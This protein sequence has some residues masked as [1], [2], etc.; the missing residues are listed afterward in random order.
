MR[1]NEKVVVAANA[2]YHADKVGYFQFF[3]EGPSLGTV[4]LSTEPVDN[5]RTATLFAVD[6]KNIIL[7]DDEVWSWNLTD[8]NETY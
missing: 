1:L 7:E 8:D 6:I 4:V 5:F 2:K 3:G